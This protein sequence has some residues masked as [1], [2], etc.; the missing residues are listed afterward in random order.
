MIPRRRA[1]ILLAISIAAGAIAFK[2]MP[3]PLPEISRAQL[4]A[5]VQAGHVH[6]VT[7]TDGEVLT[8]VSSSRGAFRLSLQKSGQD[9]AGQLSA[10]GVVVKYAIEEPG[11]I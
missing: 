8:G 4:L 2:L 5:E 11:L 7:I 3:K 9:L 6:E 10:L 1:L